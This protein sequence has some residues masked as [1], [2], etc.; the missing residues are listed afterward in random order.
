MRY[1]VTVQLDGADVSAGVLFT[2]ARRGVETVSFAYAD[3]YLELPDAFPL[4][5]DLPLVAGTQHA[6]GSRLFGAF[7]DCM[8]D[9]WGRNLLLREERRLARG[10]N[11]AAR[12]LFES[13]FLAGVSDLTREGAVRLWRD[14]AALAPQ[15]SGVP[16]ET[17]LPNLLDAADLAVTDMDAD[18]RDL[19]A[20][21]SS[22]GG[23]RPKASIISEAGILCIAKFPKADEGRLEDVCAWEHVVQVLASKAGIATPRTRLVRVGGRAVLL[24]ERFDRQ[25]LRRIPY[26]SG[27]SAIQGIDG[28]SYSY[29]ELVDFLEREGE[30]P[31]GDSRELWRR[32]LLS[33][34]IGNTDDHMRNQGLLRGRRGWRLAPMF[35]VNPTPGDNPKYLTCS[36]DL[37]R[38]DASPQVAVE[39]SEYFRV[40]RE[41]ARAYAHRLVQVLASWERV[42][43]ADG[44]AKASVERMRSCFEAGISRLRGVR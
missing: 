41:E 40:G 8:P 22:L 20:A 1:D 12:T 7:E 42:A 10:E 23:A 43:V 2:A 28:G 31:E 15:K 11:R 3:S 25:G 29:L 26:L 44:I 18:I 27:L 32:V 5:P 19:L 39:A 34:A 17:S 13:N 30:A 4:S 33:C 24:L 9:R 37:D 16:R 38:S 36:I 35:D 14:G 6:V 21:G